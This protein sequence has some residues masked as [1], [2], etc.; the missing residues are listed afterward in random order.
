MRVRPGARTRCSGTSTATNGETVSKETRASHSFCGLLPTEIVGF[1]SLA[2]LALDLRWSW[3]HST[4]EVWRRLD[5][6]LWEITHNPW[7]MLQTVSRDKI[8]RTLADPGFRKTLI[9]WYKT[10]GRRWRRPPGSSRTRRRL[11]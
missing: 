6:E 5:P 7:G 3:N 1:D 4:D 9:P 2:E 10:G 11:P 8:K